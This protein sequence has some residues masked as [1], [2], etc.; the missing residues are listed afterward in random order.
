MSLIKVSGTKKSKKS[1]N[2]GMVGWLTIVKQGERESWLV[3]LVDDVC[4]IEETGE[5]EELSRS[6]G[7]QRCLFLHVC[8]RLSGKTIL[9]MNKNKP[10]LE[11]TKVPSKT[12]QFLGQGGSCGLV[13]WLFNGIPRGSVQHLFLPPSSILPLKKIPLYLWMWMCMVSF[14]W[15][16]RSWVVLQHRG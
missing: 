10:N 3:W 12:M 1:A 11:E 8:L 2:V 6:S 14:L 4:W 5:I 16:R 7:C 15:T 13:R 9:R